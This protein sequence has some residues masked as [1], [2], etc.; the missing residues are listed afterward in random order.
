VNLTLPQAPVLWG[1]AGVFAILAAAS[2]VEFTL[3][4]LRPERDYRELNARISSWWVM[5]TIFALAIVLSPLVSVAFLGFVSFL[6]LKEYFSLIPT[7]RADRRV[8]F[9]AYLAIPVQFYWVGIEWY[10][11]F[12]IFVPV[13]MFLFLPFAMILNGQTEGFLRA[14]GSLHWGLMTMVFAISHAAY[15]LA[16]PEEGNPAAGGP[17]LLLFL[18]FLTQF[19]DVAQYVWGKSFGRHKVVP[20]VSPNKTVE[21]LLG[22]L[23]TTTLLAWLIAPHVTPLVS[24]Q[25]PVAGLIIGS[26]GFVGDVT[27]S[28]LK[29]DLG[30]KDSGS[31]IPGPGGILD[32]VDSLTFAAPLFF[33]YVY[34]LH[35]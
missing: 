23:G 11:M 9:W 20:T 35:Y 33:H 17:G 12:I 31:L 34:Y 18:V 4:K 8:L 28:A 29:R 24:W 15:L 26:A 14:A 16:L 32:R 13:Y 2:I 22:G 3:R 5:V 21:G 6:A 19:N 7:R 25:A 27:I 1:I 10:G 30:V